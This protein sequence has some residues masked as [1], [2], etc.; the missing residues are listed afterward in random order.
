MTITNA[1][2]P[3]ERVLMT[4]NH[5]QPDRPPLVIGVSNATSIKMH[6][7]RRLKGLL[8]INA[9]DRYLYDW[10]ELGT[11]ELDEDTLQHLGGDVRGLWDAHPAD[12]FIAMKNRP[13]GTP[14]FDSWG[15][16]QVEVTPDNW[17]PAIHPLASATRIEDLEAYPWPDMDDPSRV[18]GVRERAAALRAEGR[19]AIMGTPWLLFP[20][21]RAIA[22][23]GMESFFVNLVENR[24][25]ALALLE[26]TTALCKQ[27]MGHFLRELGENVDLIK[28][29][30]DLGTQESLLMSP[31]MYRRLVKPF[32]EDYITFIKSNTNAKVFFHT[33]GDVF[34][35]IPDFVEMGVDVLNPIQT[36][37]GKMSNLEELKK[38][39][40]RNLT[41][42]G[43]IDT[44]I[45]L[46]FRTP[47]D[48]RREVH[49]V[50]RALEPGGG[51][52][53]ASVHT[54]LNDVPPENILAMAEASTTI[55]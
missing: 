47:A 29:G 39:Y 32:H 7:Y 16:G 54:I 14:F 6:P 11:A 40:G 30:D 37:A 5:E 27:L 33:D 17:F 44:H 45:I 43:G 20:L 19:Y 25:F 26:K 42:C 21:E 2:S 12:N 24:E 38:Y 49:R 18:G 41:F 35:L 51:Y 31:W 34:P 52:M 1:I 48:V 4:L 22:L 46:P 13:P 36:S 53:V 9:P 8:G 15:I 10:P 23:Q 3:R 50:R 28:I 55:L